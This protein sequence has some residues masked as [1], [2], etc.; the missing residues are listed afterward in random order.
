VPTTRLPVT[1]RFLPLDTDT[2]VGAVAGGALGGTS[3]GVS[4]V[5]G[6]LNADLYNRQLH[7]D[8]KAAIHKEAN[9]DRAKEKCL[10]DAS[11]YRVR[12]WAEFSPN[13][14]EWLANH[15]SPEEASE[16]GPELQWLTSQQA[17]SGSFVYT[18]PEQ[19]KDWGLSELDQFRRGVEQFGQELKNL[20]RDI[21]NT[22]I[23]VPSEVQQG[24]ASPQAD[25]TGWNDRSPP[26]A[27]AVV[28]PSVMPCGPGVL[29]PTAS[30][31]LV[32]TSG[33]PMLSSGNGGD[34][35]LDN[36]AVNP[37]LSL[38]DWQITNGRPHRH[39]S[40]PCPFFF[41]RIPARQL[42]SPKPLPPCS[43]G[44]R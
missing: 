6:A 28:T 7:L 2:L 14:P 32:V 34:D 24:D 27:T 19:V 18:V 26:T 30:V 4:G 37:K 13:S 15:V 29:C 43:T 36:H 38:S 39:L 41:G 16:L 3:A 44:T 21:V 1:V 22:R 12:Y 33:A 5:G 23:R 35:D 11:C 42:V 31:T 17:R 25:I 9:G 20:P 8:E 40:R 10:T